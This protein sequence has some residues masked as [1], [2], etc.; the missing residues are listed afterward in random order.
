[1]NRTTAIALL[2]V[3][4]GV[5]SAFRL[6]RLPES[7]GRGDA[8]YDAV[9]AQEIIHG[10]GFSTRLMPLGGLGALMQHHRAA[11]PPWPSV[12]KFVLSQ[13][14]VALFLPLFSSI[15]QALVAASL[16][17]FAALAVL[18][19]LL[20]QQHLFS[21]GGAFIASVFFVALDPL[22]RFAVSGLNITGDALLFVLACVLVTRRRAATAGVVTA[23]LVLHRYSMIVFVPFALWAAL[24][25]AGRRSAMRMAVAALTVLVPF[26]VWSVIRTGMLFPSYLGSSLLLH[27]TPF[28]ESDPWYLHTWPSATA[29]VAHAPGVF[30]AKWF[31]NAGECLRQVA[32]TPWQLARALAVGALA[33]V[34]IRALARGEARRWLFPLLAFL[35]C[36]IGAQ[37]LLSRASWYFAFLT[38]LVWLLACAGLQQLT[39]TATRQVVRAAVFAGAV[40]VLTSPEL[41]ADLYRYR[42]PPVPAPDELATR[43][44][45]LTFLGSYDRSV[46]MGGN[47]PWELAPDSN[48]PIVA[49]AESP[50][51]LPALRDA[52]FA[53]DLLYL[54]TDLRF[55]GDGA[56]PHGWIVWN[57]LVRE[58]P[59]HFDQYALAHTFS[60]GALAY[61]KL[62]GAASFCPSSA[63]IDLIRPGDAIHLSSEFRYLETDG[64]RGWSWLG[65][66]NGAVT[67]WLCSGASKAQLRI[68]TIAR[69]SARVSVGGKLAG[70]ISPHADWM[71]QA[72]D[73][74]PP[75]D[76]NYVIRFEAD[77]TNLTIALAALRLEAR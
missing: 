25:L 33:I 32:G 72:F 58:H 44:E 3:A 6:T 66:A 63:G 24:R 69:T 42:H 40:V 39:K 35:A 43:T 41:G 37:F 67:L 48:L 20:L 46:V 68:R 77:G 73:V 64:A 49:L 52:G 51:V 55:A 2:L 14:R 23:L 7:M 76:G 21:V 65:G 31:R 53:P 19:F 70:T 57:E 62:A 56:P 12:H 50:N 9:V 60:D 30:V 16:V 36:F 45:I 27:R 13:V 18:L 29:A 10:N 54:P 38:P 61:V 71:E 11:T 26:F 4:L 22:S 1:M 47:R 34:G 59:E 15:N 74:D 5:V 75:R 8:L 17:P 28:L